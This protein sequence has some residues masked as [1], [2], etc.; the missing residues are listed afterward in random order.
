M[1]IWLDGFRALGSHAGTL[2]SV[3]LILAWGQFVIHRALS[4][5]FGKNPA[6]AEYFSLSISGWLLPVGLW[7]VL[8]FSV[9]ALFGAAVGRLIAAVL[10]L[11]SLFMVV[12]RMERISISPPFAALIFFLAVSLVLRSA[13]LQ[14]AVLPSYFDSAEHYRLIKILLEAKEVPANGQGAYYHIGYHVLILAFVRFFQSNI[15]EVMLVFGQVILAIL[16]V[17]LFFIARRETGSDAAALFTVLLA[18][19][20]WHMPA[21]LLD[22]GK[23]P[24]L[25]GLVC[26]HFVLGLGYAAYRNDRFEFR[27]LSLYFMLG[28]GVF[29]SVLIHTRS[30]VFFVMLA[31]ALFAVERRK[32]L[33]LKFQRLTFACL[34]AILT[35]EIGCVW[36]SPVLQPLVNGYRNSDVWML[37]LIL[38]LS[39]FAAR[40]HNDLTFLLLLLPALLF[41][42]LFIPIHIPGYGVQ[43]L[44][45]RPYVQMMMY[46]PLSILGGLGLSGL[47]Q[48][49]ARLKPDWQPPARLTAFLLFGLVLW[50]AS[51]RHEF[52]PSDCCQLVTYDDLAAIAWMDKTLP[53][54]ANILIASAGLYVTALESP[55]TRTGVDGGIWIAPLISRSAALA[56]N[57][58]RLDQPEGHALLCRKNLGYIYVGG[59]PQSF[60]ADL[61]D[62][63]PDWYQAVF[64]L[65]AAKVYRVAGCG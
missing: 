42:G 22:W 25:L 40:F 30:L 49:L 48:S 28:A 13:F 57:G 4:K 15:I 19:F 14:K 36:Q 5:I 26:V 62:D 1:N 34:L 65:P 46:L 58:L 31:A 44:L 21:H 56:P 33:P 39:L 16:P 55:G 2:A 59:M 10:L 50:N 24:A 43:T 53:P 35:V 18:G 64:S 47:T 12:K 20:G 45:D 6:S 32:R 37:A 60:A 29:T 7:A 27:R 38:F 23:Y 63:L 9:S 3:L 8:L 11:L 61:L 54:D 51:L 52:Y 41:S 17:S